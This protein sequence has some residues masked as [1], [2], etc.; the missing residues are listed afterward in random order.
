MTRIIAI[1]A[2]FAAA[3]G[4]APAVNA[5]QWTPYTGFYGSASAGWFQLQ[6]RD[7][8]V[9]NGASAHAEYDPGYALT[10]AGGYSFGNGF[11]AEIEGGYAHADIDKASLGG[12][13]ASGGETEFWSVFGAAY[14]DFTVDWPVR[15]YLGGGLGWV[16]TDTDAVAA[17]TGR[18]GGGG[19]DD[20]AAFAEG[21]VNYT[22][23]DKLELVPGVRYTWYNDSNNGL[24]ENKSWLFK[25]GLRYRF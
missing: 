23:N 5:Q 18:A 25:V 22:L 10:A 1:A 9:S 11:R 4:A 17:G 2:L 20:W 6:D 8:T 16:H 21:G 12:V 24:D 19:K 13:A 14:Y 7:G 15:P 3:V